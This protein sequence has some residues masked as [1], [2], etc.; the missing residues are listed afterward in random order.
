MN[1]EEL[2]LKAKSDYPIGT[3]FD[4]TAGNRNCLIEK[5]AKYYFDA[6]DDIAVKISDMEVIGRVYRSR[7]KVWAKIISRP[8]PKEILLTTLL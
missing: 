8:E 2:L 1:K 5:G 3:I 6:D 7:D 4:S